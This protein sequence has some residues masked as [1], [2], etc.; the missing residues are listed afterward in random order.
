MLKRV[1]DTS[2]MCKGIEVP[3]TTTPDACLPGRARP[4]LI[5]SM[6]SICSK[7]EGGR[8]VPKHG[9]FYR[10]FG[11]DSSS[12][13]SISVSPDEIRLSMCTKAVKEVKA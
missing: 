9:D 5:F 6:A 3:T 12:S 4:V 8:R 2:W 11:M 13:K 7:L 1:V 10:V